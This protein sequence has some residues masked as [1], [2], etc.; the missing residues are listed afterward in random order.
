MTNQDKLWLKKAA[1]AALLSSQRV[2]VGARLSDMGINFCNSRKSHPWLVKQG[3]PAYSD[4]HAEMR[5]VMYSL[6]QRLGLDGQ[7]LYVARVCRDGTLGLA[8]PCK[9]CMAVLVTSGLKRV[10]WTTGPDTCEGVRL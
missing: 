9:Y 2:R 8:K 10:V 3:F 4:I 7:T 6:L 1:T 5:A